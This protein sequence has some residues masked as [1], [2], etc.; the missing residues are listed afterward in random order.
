[1]LSDYEGFIIPNAVL[2]TLTGHTNNVK[3]VEFIGDGLASGG[4]DNVVRWWDIRGDRN[5]VMTGHKSRVWSLSASKSGQF[6]ASGSADS[7]VKVWDISKIQQGLTKCS[8][9]LSARG[10]NGDIYSVKY[11]PS[12]NHVVSA[13]YDTNIRLHD[14]RTGQCLTKFSGHTAPVC[15]VSMNPYGNL[16][17]SGSKVRLDH[18]KLTFIGPH[19]QSMGYRQWC[20]HQNNIL[21]FRRSNMRRC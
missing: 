6:L 4:S 1:L 7:T 20:L 12:E 9:T 10:S 15:S 19:N 11:H 14:I 13:S 18:Q 8:T 2:R 16:I 3:C 21:T 5:F 17:F